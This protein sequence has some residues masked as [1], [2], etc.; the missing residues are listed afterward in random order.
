[1]Y[2]MENHF[3]IGAMIRLYEGLVESIG[4]HY[5]PKFAKLQERVSKNKG[6]V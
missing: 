3:D 4:G 5:Y 1:M 6:N 2:K